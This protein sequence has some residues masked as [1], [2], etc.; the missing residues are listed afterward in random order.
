V[1]GAPRLVS[2]A[3]LW[4]LACLP[5]LAHAD[6]LPS[7]P[8]SMWGDR[9]IVSGDASITIGPRDQGYF[10]A[11]EYYHDALNVVRLG[12]SVEL[13]ANDRVSVL[14]QVIDQISLRDMGDAPPGASWDSFETNRN[15][16]RPY[17]LFVR[18]RPWTDRAIS[19]Q[20]GRIPPVFGVF[21]RQVYA[22]TEPLIS[23]PLAYHYPT[24]VRSNSVPR[25]AIG[26]MRWRGSG[27]RSRYRIGTEDWGQGVPIVSALRWDTGVQAQIGDRE[28]LFELSAAVTNG[29]LANPLFEDDNGGKQVSGR[30]AWHPTAGLV[31][32]VSLAR[33][34]FLSDEL[35]ATL[36]E[37][38]RDRSY[39]QSAFGADFEYSREYWL[40]RTETIVNGWRLPAIDPPFIE[41][42]LR[43]WATYVEGRWKLSPRWY[44]AARWEHLGFSKIDPGLDEG[45]P[46]PWDGPV[47][48]VEIGGGYTVLRNVRVKVAYQYDWRD[49]GFTRHDG[50]LAT[51]LV[52][53]F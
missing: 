46:Q 32:G 27:W 8:I 13:K 47:T 23:L 51:Q 6:F 3:T 7:K 35:I 19:I 52:Y 33:G 26:F 24:T 14:G 21:A 31:A 29:T 16:V 44:V 38:L 15:V 20:A 37:N 12:L 49:A 5:C 48:R 39:T 18:V 25:S 28:S 30:L 45:G 34:A 53:W 36:P 4:T 40:V 2:I 9:L 17:A 1:R 10:N 41:P 43:A 50:A 11:I 42:T 22:A